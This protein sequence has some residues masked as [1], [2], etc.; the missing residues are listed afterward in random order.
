MA[1]RTPKPAY[2]GEIKIDLRN[3][4]NLAIILKADPSA[5]RSR[6]NGSRT[7]RIQDSDLGEKGF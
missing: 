7:S 1:G 2:G 4:S 6:N 5:E 3:S